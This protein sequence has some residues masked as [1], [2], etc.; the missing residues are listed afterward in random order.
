MQIAVCSIGEEQI[1]RIVERATNQL[2]HHTSGV[3][4]AVHAEDHLET[5]SQLLQRL[6]HA[7]GFRVMRLTV[8]LVRGDVCQERL[9]RRPV[10]IALGQIVSVE[11]ALKAV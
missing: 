5:T 1:E 2:A 3:G 7:L 11:N 9:Q 8:E 10:R 6:D 4:A